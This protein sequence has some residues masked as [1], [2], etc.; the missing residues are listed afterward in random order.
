M[1]STT[2]NKV[3]AKYGTV[4]QPKKHLPVLQNKV[5]ACSGIITEL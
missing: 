2:C 3:T 1:P 4:L 5:G